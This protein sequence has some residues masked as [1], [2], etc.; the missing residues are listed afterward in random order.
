[1]ARHCNA[2][3][4]LGDPPGT[5][6]QV[7]VAVLMDIRDELQ[8]LNSHLRCYNFTR[9]PQVLDKINKN[10]APARRPRFTH[11]AFKHRRRQ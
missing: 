1:M 5:W 9:I 6:E 2:D 10:V 8:K 4:N 7:Q 11:T 3:W